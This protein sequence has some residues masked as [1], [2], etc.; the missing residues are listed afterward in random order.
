V[1]A[2]EEHVS[3]KE[4]KSDTLLK[5]ALTLVLL[6]VPACIVGFAGGPAVGFGLLGVLWVLAIICFFVALAM[7]VWEDD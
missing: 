4:P 3:S 1:A 5:Y 2:R 6:S 7:K